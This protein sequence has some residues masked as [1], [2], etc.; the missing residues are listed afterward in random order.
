MLFL[1]SIKFLFLV[2]FFIFSTLRSRHHHPRAMILDIGLAGIGASGEEDC[3]ESLRF[4]FCLP[5]NKS[6]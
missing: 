6:Q 5:S 2:F 4:S 1:L 3:P